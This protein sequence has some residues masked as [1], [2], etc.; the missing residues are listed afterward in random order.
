MSF[1]GNLGGLTTYVEENNFP[2]TRASVLGAKMMSLVTVVPNVKGGD[3]LPQLSQTVVF[4]ADDCAF[5]PSGATTISQRTMTPGAIKVN[6]KWCPKDL[7]PYYMVQDMKA[8]AKMESVEPDYIWKAI[9][10]EYA[11][12]IA[13]ANDIA[14]WQGDVAAGTGNNA[15][16]D[17]FIDTIGAGFTDANTGGVPLTTLYSE[18]AAKEMVE[19]IYRTASANGLSEGEAGITFIGYDT[20]S[21][22]YQGLVNG[23]RC[24]NQLRS[25][26]RPR[27]RPIYRIDFSRL[28]HEDCSSSRIERTRESLFRQAFKYVYRC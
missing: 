23:G 18:A 24:P 25:K 4:Q 7:E 11:E 19:R 26:W 16:F 21:W 6:D 13:A 14:I 17:G 5:A 10:E 12:K 1:T 15:F 9:M 3:K 27:C 22:L 8:G 20:Y 2:L 28:Q